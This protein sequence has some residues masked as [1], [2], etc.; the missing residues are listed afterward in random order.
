MICLT[1]LCLLVNTYNPNLRFRLILPSEAFMGLGKLLQLK[2]HI[3]DRMKMSIFQPTG[4]TCQSVT[5]LKRESSIQPEPEYNEGPRDWQNLFAIERFRNIELLFHIFYYNWGK[6][7]G[8]LY[9]DRCLLCIRD[10]YCISRFHCN[11]IS[12]QRGIPSQM[13]FCYWRGVGNIV[14]QYRSRIEIRC[15]QPWFFKSGSYCSCKQT[16]NRGP[17]DGHRRIHS[18]NQV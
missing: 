9:R 6:E 5:Y 11:K 18:V 7:N 14:R 13:F 16:L 3:I 15:I 8:S 17:A 4:I 12:L 2:H 1:S 10:R